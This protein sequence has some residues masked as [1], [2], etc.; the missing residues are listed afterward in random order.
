[1]KNNKIEIHFC[2]KCKWL[3][4]S[5][6]MA[7]ELM[8]TFAEELNEVSLIKAEAGEFYIFLNKDRIWSRKGDGGFPEIKILKQ[9]VRDRLAPERSLGHSDRN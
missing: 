4:R 9:L 6:W 3:L 1:M 5:S 7:Q 2:H 8:I